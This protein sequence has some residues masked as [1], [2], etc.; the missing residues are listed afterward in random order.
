MCKKN[1]EDIKD[2]LRL[3]IKRNG[4]QNIA[5]KIENTDCDTVTS[6]YT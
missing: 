6:M 2:G 4:I 3:P 5:A 1:R